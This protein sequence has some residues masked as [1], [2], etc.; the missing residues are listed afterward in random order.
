MMWFMFML[1]GLGLLEAKISGQI[2]V[3]W[4]YVLMP[5]AVSMYYAYRAYR[6]KQD[7]H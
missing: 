2:H 3:G 5:F 1:A 4:A 7:G 6:E